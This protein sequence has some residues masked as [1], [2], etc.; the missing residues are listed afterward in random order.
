VRTLRCSSVNAT[1]LAAITKALEGAWPGEGYEL[2]GLSVELEGF[3]VH[4][5][6]QAIVYA[7]ARHKKM[8]AQHGAA[9][10]LDIAIER[11]ASGGS[12][13]AVVVLYSA[14]CR[15]LVVRSRGASMDQICT[16]VKDGLRQL[17]HLR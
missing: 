5:V 15:E 16:A 11:F 6:D 10:F 3:D 9:A 13:T 17:G 8:C 14:G 7:R 12:N 2:L 1:D 4:T